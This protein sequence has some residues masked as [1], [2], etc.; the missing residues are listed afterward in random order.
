MGA[1]T[2]RVISW[3]SCGAP[4]AVATK[5][6]IAKYGSRVVVAYC[7][8]GAEHPDNERYIRDCE[9]WFDRKV[10]RLKSERYQDTWEVWKHQRYLAGINGAKCT[11]ELKIKP[12]VAFQHVDDLHV[13]GYTADGLDVARAKRLRETFFE[14]KIETPLISGGLKKEACLAMVANAGIK[15]PVLYGLGFPNNNCIPCP[16]ATSA[17]YWALVRQ[18]F[19]DEFQRIAALARELGVRLCRLNG[20]RAFIDEIP[21]DHP[22][23]NPIAPSC[24]FLCAL[25][26]TEL[27]A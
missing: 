17:A 8:T 22:T 11:A 24:D 19:P 14:L 16:K 20:D 7:D 25:A 3:F 6:A 21:P 12:R 5:L 10:T 13:F 9:A 27:V 18:E 15:L 23:T 1:V 4:S 2:T 26:E